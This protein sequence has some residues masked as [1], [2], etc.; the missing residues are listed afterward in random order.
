M[1]SPGK[2][3]QHALHI[4]IAE[5]GKLAALNGHHSEALRHYREAMKLAQACAA[6]EIFFRHYTQCTLESLEKTGAY[7]EV[8]A[9]CE[10]ADAHYA[11]LGTPLAVMARDHAS[12]LE[13]LGIN[14]LLSGQAET[15]K[16]ALVAA[17]QLSQHGLPITATLLGWLV[18]GLRPDA[19]RISDLQRKHGYFTVRPDQVDASRARPL[20]EPAKK[21]PARAL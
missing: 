15:G 4:G 1:S 13:R 6:P 16:A 10:G 5:A 11:A 8:I 19:R 14:R 21:E 18:R 7:A 3:P 9:F 17:D 2:S 12:I 20:P